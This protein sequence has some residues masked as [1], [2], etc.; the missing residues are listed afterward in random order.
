MYMLVIMGVLVGVVFIIKLGMFFCVRRLDEFM[1]IYV[2]FFWFYNLCWILFEF[3]YFEEC[4]VRVVLVNFIIFW[5]SIL[6]GKYNF[7]FF[8]VVVCDDICK[9]IFLDFFN[10]FFVCIVFGCCFDCWFLFFEEN[11]VEEFVSIF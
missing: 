10:E 6:L 4:C 3:V 5:C 1:V 7:F 8:F 9:E 2:Y 11:Y